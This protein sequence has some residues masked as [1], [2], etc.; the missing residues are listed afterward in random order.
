MEDIFKPDYTPKQM[1]EI[2]VFGGAYFSI[3]ETFKERFPEQLFE[4]LQ[5]N[6]YNLKEQD[7]SVNCFKVLAGKSYQWWFERNLISE[8]DPLGWFEWYIHYYYGRRC[9]DDQRQ[10]MRWFN[11]KSRQSSIYRTLILKSKYSV[12][13]VNENNNIYPGMKQS[14]IQWGIDLTNFSL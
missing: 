8:I 11:F 1:L 3:D 12:K 14:F 13:Q 7:K 4:G 10:I 5:E 9:Y 6:K 2:G